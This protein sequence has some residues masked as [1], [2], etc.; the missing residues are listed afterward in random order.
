M[1]PA[2]GRHALTGA[3]RLVC[4]VK[5]EQRLRGVATQHESLDARVAEQERACEGRLDD[6]EG[7][8][9]VHLHTPFQVSCTTW[10]KYLP[11]STT[12]LTM[13]Q[14]PNLFKASC[15]DDHQTFCL[16]YSAQTAC[17]PQQ[18]VF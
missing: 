4:R 15:R 17:P 12:R 16:I 10:H 18:T 1:W 2:C 8:L 7:A 6:L 3:A 11:N 14:H 5:Q 9:K 13:R